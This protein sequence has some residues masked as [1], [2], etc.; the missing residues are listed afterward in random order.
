MFQFT[1]LF[2]S[3]ALSQSITQLNVFVSF[4]IGVAV[5]RQENVFLAT[6]GTIY[7]VSSVGVVDTSYITGL[8]S[9][10]DIVL[11]NEMNLYVS[12]YAAPS[13][14]KYDK[15]GIADLMFDG[16]VLGFSP[17]GLAFSDASTTLYVFDSINNTIRMIDSAGEL[18]TTTALE[19][20]FAAGGY[21]SSKGMDIDLNGNFIIGDYATNSLIKLLPNGS[22]STFATGF[23][24]PVDIVIDCL[25]RTFVANSG[26]GTISI[27]TTQG[28]TSTYFATNLT[29]LFGIDLDSS[30]NLYVT[31]WATVG[32][33]SKIVPSSGMCL[34]LS[35]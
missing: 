33:V 22:K 2:G 26:N 35:L 9:A 15:T 32:K 29:S 20:G 27:V 8:T 7:K 11:D 3:V 23:N 34:F 13:V 25:G 17:T 5:D 12:D 30:G 10:Y 1:L 28:A 6:T 31:N 16:G 14:V 4:P 18:N 21:Y 19:I 24:L